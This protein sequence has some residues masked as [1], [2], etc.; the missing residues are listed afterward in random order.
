MNGNMLL[1]IA[2]RYNLL[3]QLIYMLL[4]S[5]NWKAKDLSIFWNSKFQI[6]TS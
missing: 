2:S 5:Y 6:K 4:L 3:A 1:M